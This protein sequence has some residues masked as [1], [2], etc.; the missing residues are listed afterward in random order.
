MKDAIINTIFGGEIWKDE[1]VR[2]A[3]ATLLSFCIIII[4]MIFL[5]WFA[6]GVEQETSLDSDKITIVSGVVVDY[7]YMCGRDCISSFNIKQNNKSMVKIKTRQNFDWFFKYN[8][9]PNVT[10]W[11]KDFLYGKDDIYQIYSNDKDFYIYKF[12]AK[13]AENIK[14]PKIGT[15]YKILS[16]LFVLFLS[17]YF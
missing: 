5:I 17:L 2:P 3:L 9:Y 1:G 11:Y 6:R 10:I 15:F 13:Q 16:G 7:K 4:S 8:K 14:H 12:D